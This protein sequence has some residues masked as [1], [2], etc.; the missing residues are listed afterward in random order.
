MTTSESARGRSG[1]ALVVTTLGATVATADLMSKTW[2]VNVLADGDIALAGAFRLALGYNSGVAF[3]VGEQV[4][5]VVLGTVALAIAV[6]LLAAAVR[7]HIAAW[8][9]GLVVGGAVGN[10]LDRVRDGV[11]IDFLDVGSW[12]TFNVADVA[13]VAG[14][15]ALA[16][17]VYREE[18]RDTPGG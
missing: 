5:P 6:A 18:I 13:I 11:V 7:R 2:A 12:P 10:L 1:P 9:G 8:A 14:S 17:S 16:A 4:P 15:L 3:G